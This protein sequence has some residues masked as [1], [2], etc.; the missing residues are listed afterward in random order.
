MAAVCVQK[1]D[2]SG[3]DDCEGEQADDGSED[4]ARAARRWA[5]LA[6]AEVELPG[7]ELREH[8]LSINP[9]VIKEGAA[10]MSS[11]IEKRKSYGRDE[12][13]YGVSDDYD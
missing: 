9:A 8:V 10:V 6:G 4:V 1:H 3:K 7:Q 13:A 11:S 12:G 5:G 2:G